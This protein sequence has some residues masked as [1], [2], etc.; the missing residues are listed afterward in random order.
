MAELLDPGKSL[1]SS[2]PLMAAHFDLCP[3]AA[4]IGACG[5][6]MPFFVLITD[7]CRGQGTQAIIRKHLE[8][9]EGNQCWSKTTGSVFEDV[10]N[11]SFTFKTLRRPAVL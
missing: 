5:A 8:G 9:M 6:E 2:R 7:C 1:P 4:K 3:N 11:S 10:P